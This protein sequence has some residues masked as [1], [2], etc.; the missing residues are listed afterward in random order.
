MKYLAKIRQNLCDSELKLLFLNEARFQIMYNFCFCR[1]MS[2]EKNITLKDIMCRLM[3]MTYTISGKPSIKVHKLRFVLNS[4]FLCTFTMLFC[5]FY[6]R[7]LQTSDECQQFVHKT[8]GKVRFVIGD[9]GNANENITVENLKPGLHE[10]VF[11]PGTPKF[12]HAGQ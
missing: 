10:K 7:L 8:S 3:K 9:D 12:W 2:I 1:R 11:G 5:T 4:L 6:I